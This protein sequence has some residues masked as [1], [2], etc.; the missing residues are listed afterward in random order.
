[1]FLYNV[2]IFRTNKVWENYPDWFDRNQNTQST[3]D[4]PWGTDNATNK[5]K[6]IPEI[7]ISGGQSDARIGQS[8]LL[9]S[10][11][12]NSSKK[13]LI[14]TYK[15]LPAVGFINKVVNVAVDM[16]KLD[17]PAVATTTSAPVNAP[18]DN[19]SIPDSTTDTT[20][21]DIKTKTAAAAAV[22]TDTT[23]NPAVTQ[24]PIDSRSTTTDNASTQSP[25]LQLV[26]KTV[27]LNT[28]VPMFVYTNG[29]LKA[30]PGKKLNP[31]GYPTESVKILRYDKTNN[32]ALIQLTNIVSK[33][34]KNTSGVK[35]KTPGKPITLQ[36]ADT[37]E[38]IKGPAS[39]LP[40]IYISTNGAYT[41]LQNPNNKNEKFFVATSELK[42]DR[43]P[44]WIRKRD[45]R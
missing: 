16:P 21:V 27:E 12:W 29:K 30:I 8:R 41:L 33:L 32:Y 1:M 5:T 4:S 20:N 18:Q 13:F 15:P 17:E 36:T 3:N 10:E 19:I 14:K 38:V 25:S 37:K 39:P 28:D 34:P 35:F 22:A 11:R 2:Y 9:N 45:I 43:P 24:T 23:T 7:P 42:I 40:W 44:V 26:G 6:Y 31:A